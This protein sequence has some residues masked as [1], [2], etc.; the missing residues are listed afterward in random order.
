VIIRTSDWPVPPVPHYGGRLN[1]AEEDAAVLASVVADAQATQSLHRDMIAHMA[2][3]EARSPGILA[4]DDDLRNAFIANLEGL[5]S[6]Y[7]DRALGMV[8]VSFPMLLDRTNPAQAII[9]AVR[10][11]IADTRDRVQAKQTQLALTKQIAAVKISLPETLAIQAG[12][13]AA[14]VASALKTGA[15]AGADA[16]KDFAGTLAWILGG[17]AALYL[18]T[19]GG[20]K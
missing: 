1:G 12:Q 10:G 5:L 15:K 3:W 8:G 7:T 4:T 20:G 9:I 14:D 6:A 19:R 18:L 11:D 2:D 16:V 17:G 13:T